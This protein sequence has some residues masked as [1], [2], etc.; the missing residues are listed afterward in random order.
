M[1]FLAYILIYPILWM[2]SIL[3]FRLLYFVSDCLYILLYY[4]IGYRKKVVTNNLKLV[5]PE[6]S[7]NEIDTIKKKIL[8]AFMRYVFRNG[9]DY[10]YF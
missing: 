5:F 6:K 2:V 1:Q 4:V 7:E 3:P 9:K 8:Q 10:D